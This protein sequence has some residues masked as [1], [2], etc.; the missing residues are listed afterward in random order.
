M[1]LSGNQVKYK[2]LHFSGH[3]ITQMFKRGI[4][5]E[6]INNKQYEMCDL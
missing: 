5:V 2:K 4:H 3:A 1:Y 6:D